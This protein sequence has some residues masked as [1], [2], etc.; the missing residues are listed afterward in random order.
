VLKQM[1]QKLIAYIVLEM[2]SLKVVFPI[3]TYG[4]GSCYLL[5]I[6]VAIFCGQNIAGLDLGIEVRML[7]RS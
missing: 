3:D 4:I 2:L 7:I 6:V 1:W 5:K